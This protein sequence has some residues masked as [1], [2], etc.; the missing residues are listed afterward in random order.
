MDVKKTGKFIAACRKEQHM[1]QAELAEKLGI[2]NQAVS[3]WETGRSMP[4][5]G[6][7]LALCG[8]LGISVNE[9]LSGEK[10]IM[11][12]YQKQAEEN[13]LRMKK[14]E[15]AANRRLLAMEN[16]V[17]FIGAG[18]GVLLLLTGIIAV[19]AAGWKLLLLAAGAV[20]LVTGVVFAMKI[21]RESGY[22]KCSSCGYEYVPEKSRHLMSVHLL[23][24]HYM[25]CPHCGKR[26]LQKKVLTK[27]Q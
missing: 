15:E 16:V 4:D 21:E 11:T 18:A 7:M 9:L 24:S 12:D 1:T 2:S 19:Q 27:D 6:I 25:V 26:C 10:I 22:Y 5:A 23:R 14:N 17:G 20:L 8:H 3:K 13:L